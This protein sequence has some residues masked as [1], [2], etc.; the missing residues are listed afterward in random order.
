MCKTLLKNTYAAIVALFIAMYALPQQAQ[1]QAEYDLLIC[2]TWVTS[3]NCNDLSVIDGVEGTVKYDPNTKILTLKDAKLNAGGNTCIRSQI[4]GLTIEVSGTNELNATRSAIYFYSA[5]ATITGGGTLNVKSQTNCGIYVNETNLTIKDCIVNAKGRWG[6]TG[7]DVPEENL[8]IK[9]ATVTAE[10]KDGSICDFKEITLEGCAITQPVGAEFDESMKA[11]VLNGE[12]VTSEVKIEPAIK[13]DL[14]ICGTQVTSDHCGDLSKISGVEGTVKYDP[15]TQTLTLKDAELFLGRSGNC[16]RSGIDGLTI[17]VSG[18]NRLTAIESSAIIVNAPTTIT[19]DGTLHAYSRE[20]C[21]IYAKETDLTIKDCTVS[22]SGKWGITGYYNVSAKKLLIKN[23]TVI[24]EGTYGSICDFKEITLEGCTITQPAGA[25]NSQGAIR[26]NGEIVKSVVR[27]ELTRYALKICGT[28]VTSANCADLST[29]PGILSGKASYDPET[30]TLT[31]DNVKAEKQNADFLRC[32][33]IPNLKIVLVGKNTANTKGHTLYWENGNVEISGRGSLTARS[34]D[35]LAITNGPESC[36]LTIKDCTLDVRGNDYSIIGFHNG[37]GT[38]SLT[39]VVDN[40]T[41]KVKGATGGWG[42]KN[43]GIGALKSYELRNCYISTPGVKFGKKYGN[44][45]YEF[46]GRDGDT[47]YGEVI[48]KPATTYDL[49][50]AGTQVCS[51]NCADLSTIPGISGKASYDPGTKT[52][53]LMDATLNAERNGACIW[54]VIDGLTIK[55]SGTNELNAG[56]LATI[57]VYAPTTITG[58]GTLNAKS[59]EYAAICA[60]TT[61]LTIKDC[62]VNAKGKWGI[63]GYKGS[64]EE[65]HISNATVTAEGKNGSIYNF[66]AIMLEGCAITRPIGAKFDTSQ[67]AVVLNGEIVKSEVKIEPITYYA[68]QICGTQVTSAN[69]DDLSTIPGILSGKASY[70]P[71]TTTLTFDNV[72][73]EKQNADFLRCYNIPNLKIV[74]VGKNTANTKGHTLYWENGN[75]EIS[76]RGSLTARSGDNLAIMNGPESCKL[77][78]KDCT[79]DVQGKNYSIVGYH[80]GDNTESL[81]LVVDNATVKVKGSTGGWGWKNSGIG[82]LKAYEL[83]NCYISTP[84][85]K[86]GKVYKNTYYELV[87]TDGDTYYGEVTIKPATTY[88][89][90]IAGT[91]VSSGNCADLSTIPGISGKVSYDPGT[92]T[93]TLDNAIIN[94]TAEGNNGIGIENG[95]NGLTL[96]LIGENTITAEKSG[97]IRNGQAAALNITGEGKLTVNGSTTASYEY[98]RFGFINYGTV[99][100]SN[101]ALE[102]VGGRCGLSW[103]LWKFDHCNIR[104]KGSGSVDGPSDGSLCDMSDYPEFI[105]CTITSPTGTYWKKYDTNGA[106]SLFGADDKVVTDWVTIAAPTGINTPTID[107]AA[108]QGIYTLSGVKLSGEM[109]DLPKGVYIVNGK[110]VVK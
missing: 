47:Y 1:A 18:T 41:V 4:D 95:I 61:D 45:Y 58:G 29:I 33:N 25:V 23:A 16:I 66:K 59:E 102:V 107:T 86:F 51:G 39:L 57:F 28:Q 70:D 27:I 11:V 109:K 62:I 42:W 88:N 46:V 13:Y 68:L 2:G 36:K 105:G 9:N 6:I 85:V 74:L 98:Y 67:K 71:E 93:L 110:K 65:L 103:G 5:P 15:N 52:L 34:G 92:K 101:C 82:Y 60:R 78:I 77:T 90:W 55:V 106:Y 50:L 91:Q 69:C 96:R 100:V 75:V 22:A 20:G 26:L 38:E 37:P 40:A 43:S 83:R 64:N 84:G 63:A 48:I 79:L 10:G 72:K 17:K 76:G 31:F 12:V 21:G 44:T 19:G 24:A 81:T 7:S 14:F 49:W 53:T 73:A 87:G 108:K 32:Y 30:T 3:D 54:S 8:L 89:L 104:A 80:N 97:G 35:N 56:Y 94:T 99:T